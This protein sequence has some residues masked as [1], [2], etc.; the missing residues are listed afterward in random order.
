M[1]RDPAPGT[2]RLYEC[3]AADHSLLTADPGCEGQQPLGAVGYVYTKAVPGSVP[4]YR[5]YA[6]S[7]FDHFVSNRADCEGPYVR[8]GLLGHVM[9]VAAP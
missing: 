1:L 5:C 6:P 3:K 2:V 4:L 9:P 7:A 8:E